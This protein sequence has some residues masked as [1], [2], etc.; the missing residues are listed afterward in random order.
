MSILP[1]LLQSQ[2]LG[3]L[4]LVAELWGLEQTPRDLE[5]GAEA[6]A[7]DRSNAIPEREQAISLKGVF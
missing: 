5:A 1:Q 2:D 7:S 6:A 4:R 3:H